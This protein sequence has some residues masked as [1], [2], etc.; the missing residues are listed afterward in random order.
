MVN[1]SHIFDPKYA[2]ALESKNRQTWQNREEIINLLELKPSY[3]VADLGCGSGYFTVPISRKVKKVYGI[4]VQEEML[5]FLEQ[6]IREQKIVNIE[7]LLSKED[8]IPLQDESVDLVLS[9]NTLHEFRDKETTI[10][11]IK[12]VLK[13]KGHVVI[14]DFKTEDSDF[15]PPISIRVSE[16]QAKLLFAQKA[17]T[18]MK[19]HHLKYHYLIVLRKDDV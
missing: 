17:L 7:T 14:V 9:V 5:E 8:M 1:E 19:T 6:K 13:P 18:T 15:G 10:S 16:E 4:D 3:V 12:R 11:E 2:D